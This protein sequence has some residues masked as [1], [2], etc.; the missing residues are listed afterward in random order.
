[1]SVPWWAA[2][3]PAQ[4]QISCGA[5]QHVVRWVDG[6][7]TA[8]DHPDAEGELVLAALGGDKSECVTLVEA[9]GAHTEDLDVLAL[10]PRSLADHLTVTWDLV[11]SLRSTISPQPGQA[12]RQPARPA[13]RPGRPPAG[14]LRP[15]SL[16]MRQVPPEVRRAQARRAELIGLF[17]LGRDFQLAL[18]GTVAAAWSAGPAPGRDLAAAR[19]ALTA[20]LAG[21]LAPAAAGWL[22]ID[23]EAVRA[24]L[25]DGPGWGTVEL[26]GGTLRAALPARW[27]A[28][29]WAAG[30]PVVD[31]HLVVDVLAATWPQAQVRALTRP[32]AAPVVRSIRYDGEHWSVAGAD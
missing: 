31:G 23:P 5:G 30:C 2:V 24:E 22:G 29:V 21:R 27:L 10:G 11:S 16:P 19:P 9:W 18:S 20:A 25:Y 28:A 1:V 17:A 26:A 7:L 15:R 8:A 13:Q 32:G 12:L 4:S 14:R 3:R 6:A